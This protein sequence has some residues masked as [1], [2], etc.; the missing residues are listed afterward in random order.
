MGIE[1]FF[2]TWIA[3]ESKSVSEYAFANMIK[4][5]IQDHF[6]NMNRLSSRADPVPRLQES[7]PGTSLTKLEFG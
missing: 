7:L 4:S 3:V 6:G 2:K 1:K 5:N